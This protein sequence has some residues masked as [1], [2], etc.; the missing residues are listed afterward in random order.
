MQFTVDIDILASRD[1]V[2]EVYMQ[3]NND[4]EWMIGLQSSERLRGSTGREGATR[5]L[6]RK[7]GN[8]VATI[9]ET[10]D[11]NDLPDEIVYRYVSDQWQE[12]ATNSFVR[13]GPNK[14][15]WIMEC[16]IQCSGV[17]KILSLINP[18]MFRKQAQKEQERFKYFCEQKV[19]SE[20]EF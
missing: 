13:S 2:I 17:A 9:T 5:T 4:S 1:Q 20:V 19:F 3:R 10:L 7:L 12:K 16:T 8:K 14:T 15:T 11:K 18:G 6:I